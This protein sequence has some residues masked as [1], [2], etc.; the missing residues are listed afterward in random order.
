MRPSVQI[1]Y[2]PP[3]YPTLL[4]KAGY[5]K[6]RDLLTYH[7]A[8]AELEERLFKYEG[9]FV[10][11]TGQPGIKLRQLSRSELERDAGIMAR[12]FSEAWDRNWG[13][14]SMLPEDLMR[15]ARDLGPF[16]DERLGGIV[17][18]DGNPGGVFLAVP[19]PWEIFHHLNGRIGWRGL[20]RIFRDRKK[21]TRYRALILGVL[22]EYRKLPIGMLI[23]EQIRQHRARFP[24]IETIEFSW[25]LE[26]NI[27]MRSITEALGGVHCHTLRV[28]EK[29]LE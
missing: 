26:D 27:P 15:A 5:L 25:I 19:D 1:A 16:F 22:P 11:S 8:V 23:M 17:M 14:F 6:V 2:T 7:V 10:P 9:A 3:Y 20:I 18:M 21:I 13:A 28:F 24:A 29:Y 12:I 4:E